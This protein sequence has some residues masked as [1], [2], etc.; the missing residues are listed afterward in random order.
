MAIDP[1]EEARKG[2]TQEEKKRRNQLLL[3][4]AV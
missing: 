2:I 1:Q 4:S 3:I